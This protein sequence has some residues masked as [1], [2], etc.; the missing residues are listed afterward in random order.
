[1][2]RSIPTMITL[3]TTGITL[4][5]LGPEHRFIHPP[6]TWSLALEDLDGD[7][8]SDILQAQGEHLY[9]HSR[10]APDEY[11]LTQ[12]LGNFG[13]LYRL[14]TTDLDD[15]GVIDIVLPLRDGDAISWLKGLGSGAYDAPSVLITGVDAPV[16]LQ[17]H[18]M[19]GDGDKD[20]VFA[21]DT[22]SVTIAWAANEG[23]GSFSSPLIIANAGVAPWVIERIRCFD[24]GD[25]DGNGSPDVVVCG[26]TLE[27]CLNDGAG[28][29][30]ASSLGANNRRDVLLFDPDLDGDLDILTA[31]SGDDIEKRL[32]TGDG[33]FGPPQFYA[34]GISNTT[35][36][37]NLNAADMDGDGD[38]D[39]VFWL[40]GLVSEVSRVI[41]IFNSGQPQVFTP[42]DYGFE[43]LADESLAL[44][45]GDA[46]GNTTRD[47]VAVANDI[48]LLQRDDHN[49]MVRI[50]SVGTPASIEVADIDR[51]GTMDPLVCALKT[52]SPLDEGIAPL[53][54]AWHE[55]PGNGEMK[56]APDEVFSS[57]AP[58]RRV[59]PADL[60]NDGDSDL[61]MVSRDPLAYTA[62]TISWWRNDASVFTFI[63]TIIQLVSPSN[64]QY[65]LIP[66]LRDMDMDGDVDVVYDN[67]G[68]GTLL[69]L[70]N[71][72]G[73]FQFP[74]AYY[75]GNIFIPIGVALCDADQDGD[76]DHVWS[77]GDFP[78]DGLPDSLFVN[79]N[80]GNGIPGPSVY[81]GV[82]PLKLDYINLNSPL[83]KGAD[84]DADGL[85]DL[86]TFNGDSI[87]IQLNTGGAFAPAQILV[88]PGTVAYALGDM[89]ASGS[90]DIVALA[91]NGDIFF[92]AQLNDGT[93]SA[94]STL[95]SGTGHSGRTDL[96]LADMD[97]DGDLDV[98]TCALNGAAAWLE[99]D[100]N[101][102]TSVTTMNNGEGIRVFPN[103][104]SEQARVI[105]EE[106]LGPDTRIE[107]VDVS[108][109]TIR[110]M[111]GNGT[112]EVL[113][114]RGS[115]Q[116]GIYLLRI[117]PQG[118]SVS[119][120]GGSPA[121]IRIVMR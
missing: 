32:N 98:L 51:D 119:H 77:H 30:T 104:M 12:D 41:T 100:G 61:V 109:K 112:R 80:P 36:M 28:N 72:D 70:N 65:I 88:A 73:T 22:L 75:A 96:R 1:M 58:V 2:R 5:Q 74:Q 57:A 113:V 9:L 16:D 53:Q 37:T 83:R 101:M 76:P 60:D 3:L 35:Y 63:D 27:R 78:P 8:D 84:V 111:R 89:N 43:I 48:I 90:P 121:R 117:L 64:D 93:F 106:P 118:T 102:P 87:A 33:S 92:W 14:L 6:Q 105:F 31:G 95:I 91:S 38:K 94:P 52:W 17:A 120:N 71:G 79:Y 97:A 18:D 23:S 82:S 99:N 115:L 4:A 21:Y 62:I 49:S 54:L 50:T 40:D 13:P 47:I 114:E 19:D 59:L 20:L 68:Q 116:S 15:D 69:A 107:L 46:D 55:N 42:L 10:I 108:G 45:I 25:M 34:S 103:P 44:A 66:Q 85:E 7:G 26:S 67:S 81:I 39:L 86:V 11:R 56:E 110:A 29:F 24:V